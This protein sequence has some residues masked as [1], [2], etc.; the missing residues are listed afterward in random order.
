VFCGAASGNLEM[1][2]LEGRAAHLVDQLAAAAAERGVAELWDR[3]NNGCS[4]TT[5]SSGIHWMYRVGDAPAMGNTK[6][7][8]RPNPAD[9]EKP[10][11]FAETRGEGGWVVV[12]GSFGRTHA[13]GKP[14]VMRTGSPATIPTLTAAERDTI[15]ALFRTL[16]E[17]PELTAPGSIAH[18]VQRRERPD[19]QLLPG[20]DFD[21]RGTWAEAL[22][23][24]WEKISTGGRADAYSMHGRGGRKTADLYHNDNTLWIYDTECPGSGRKL[25][26][27][28]A[29]TWLHHNGD[30]RA[31]ATTLN[32]AGYG[33][34]QDKPGPAPEQQPPPV[35][36]EHANHRPT[37][38]LD[39][40]RAGLRADVAAVLERDQLPSLVLVT[41]DPGVG[42][43]QVA[44]EM[45]AGRFDKLWWVVGSHEN[46]TDT[47]A[48]LVDAGHT[49][50][51]AIPPRDAT[52]C[53]CWT[54]DDAARLRDENPGYNHAMAMADALRVGNPYMACL[55]CP[56]SGLA[57]P[58]VVATPDAAFAAF[59]A[60][61]PF[62]DAAGDEPAAPAADGCRCEFW[63][64]KRQAEA[65]RI[66]VM[67]QARYLKSG[68]P[69]APIGTSVAAVIDEHGTNAILPRQ[70]FTVA[71]LR[72]TR[73]AIATA[74]DNW[75]N[76]KTKMRFG[77]A[78]EVEHELF[79]LGEA[80]LRV[81][82]GIVEHLETLEAAGE[83]VVS[84]LP[85]SLGLDGE[86][87]PKRAHAK[88]TA[89]LAASGVPN[90]FDPAAL[91]VV[92]HVAAGT[93]AGHA[94]YTEPQ[95]G[96]SARAQ[97][98]VGSGQAGANIHSASCGVDPIATPTTGGGP[99]T[100]VFDASADVEAIRRAVPD[101]LEIAPRGSAPLAVDA[102]QW[103]QEIN[104]TT[105]PAVV[106]RAL[107]TA[108]EQRGWK[109]AAVILCK[110]HRAV[111]F[112]VTR[113]RGNRPHEDK[114]PDPE[115][116]ANWG[117]RNGRSLA[118]G[119]AEQRLFRATQLVE[120]VRKLHQFIA[121]DEMGRL[122]V[123]HHGGTAARGSNKF[124][125]DT[126]GLVVLGHTRVNPGTIAGYMLAT[127]RGAAVQRSNG[128]W[129]DVAGNLE[130]VG[131]GTTGRRWRGYACPEWAEAARQLNRAALVQVVGRCRPTLA[132]G[133]PAVVVAAEPTGLPVMD[134][135]AAIPDTV[136]SV[137]NAVRELANRTKVVPECEDG[138]THGTGSEGPDRGVS[139]KRSI[140][141]KKSPIIIDGLPDTFAVA[142]WEVSATIGAPERTTRLW[143]AEAVNRGLMVR[144]GAARAT[145]YALPSAVP[146]TAAV[147]Q[148]EPRPDTARGAGRLPRV[149]PGEPIRLPINEPPEKHMHFLSANHGARIARPPTTSTRPPVGLKKPPEVVSNAGFIE[150]A[151]I[152]SPGSGT[153]T[154]AP[155]RAAASRR[156]GAEKLPPGLP[157]PD[158]GRRR[159]GGV[160]ARVEAVAAVRPGANTNENGSRPAG[161]DVLA[162]AG[163][164]P[165][166]GGPGEVRKLQAGA[167]LRGLIDTPAGPRFTDEAPQLRGVERSAMVAAMV[168]HWNRVRTPGAEPHVAEAEAVAFLAGLFEKPP[169]L[170]PVAA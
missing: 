105:H 33:S 45:L 107:E 54:P 166:S 66:T 9:P 34:R 121:R 97:L 3:F 5:P 99:T 157:G 114:D 146:A 44:V 39:A 125:A 116:I 80:T 164:R 8:M 138:Q 23:G 152:S 47:V 77:K 38:S 88:L 145:R 156:T 75:R 95:P 1:A 37:V 61:D 151:G 104:P 140:E 35:R 126:D 36:V 2:E 100:F 21:Q 103:W 32:A 64:R 48:R 141:H 101:L 131:G 136:L 94:V 113:P 56:L 149:L 102:V 82:S 89:F 85:D 58:P 153:E 67:C 50:V 79:R 90:D 60:A 43:T 7:A 40:L 41:P 98:V 65:A 59:M 148:T 6:L 11:V 117:G 169:P 112:P 162:P 20:D 163:N 108:I 25:S 86:S 52:T 12:A 24:G 147:R 161:P 170:E 68:I 73:D 42:K 4:E 167:I 53:A 19:G 142:V 139:G 49:D 154:P 150:G 106:V 78:R 109:R 84:R 127:G 137:V 76:R 132:T 51:A 118:N 69:A 143:L 115:A 18:A 130:A 17:M 13:T 168:D 14:Y 87:I 27:F 57:K 46:A 93:L 135:P 155:G 16:D 81:A 74:V 144:S 63:N 83:R 122:L 96:G 111:L 15:H 129:G 62:A 128:G 92:R 28:A 10:H 133:V 124:I 72:A 70:T 29:Y 160:G 165:V 110:S 22:P 120:R 159:A 119:T 55:R 91:E 158:E 123:E 31:A 71:T 134:P 26:R 30:F